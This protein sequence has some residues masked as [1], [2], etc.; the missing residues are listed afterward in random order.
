MPSS[1]ASSSSLEPCD[2]PGDGL[3][4]LI[5]GVLVPIIRCVGNMRYC[6]GFLVETIC[7]PACVLVLQRLQLA[8]CEPRGNL[9]V[10]LVKHR[11]HQQDVRVNESP[12]QAASKSGARATL[13]NRQQQGPN[14][15]TEQKV[16]IEL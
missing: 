4:L 16:S 5:Y 3:L 12:Q 1:T 2:D 15:K 9:V 7:P 13:G 14:R 6:Q 10:I 8:T 11:P